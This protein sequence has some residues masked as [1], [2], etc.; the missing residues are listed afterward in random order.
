MKL[1][2]SILIGKVLLSSLSSKVHHSTDSGQLWLHLC[3]RRHETGMNACRA[4]LGF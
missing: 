4:H 3:Y 1:S 2:V